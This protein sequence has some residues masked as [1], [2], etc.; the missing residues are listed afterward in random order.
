MN[1]NLQHYAVGKAFSMSFYDIMLPSIWLVYSIWL[2]KS[3]QLV[4][5]SF[6]HINS[7]FSQQR[8]FSSFLWHYATFHS[9]WIFHHKRMIP[10]LIR[11][12][13]EIFNFW[14]QL[15]RKGVLCGAKHY[16]MNV[17][18]L[19]NLLHVE[20][21]PSTTFVALYLQL[22]DDFCHAVKSPV[23]FFVF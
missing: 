18:S 10:V 11:W 1:I 17:M 8:K 12:F 3:F 23:D 16:I 21:F 5:T 19:K 9:K 20:D 13:F 14:A 4:T 2:C 7:L 6:I 22:Q 15:T